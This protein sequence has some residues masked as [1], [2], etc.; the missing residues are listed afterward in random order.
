MA[1][2]GV[3]LA[4]GVIA[5]LAPSFNSERFRAAF[6][7]KELFSAQMMRTPVKL[8]TNESLALIGAARVAESL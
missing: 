8:V 7:A 2:G 3:F 6:C 4:G 5:K 1:R